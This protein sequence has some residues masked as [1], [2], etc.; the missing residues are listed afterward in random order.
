ML[1]MSLTLKAGL[2]APLL[3]AV[4]MS[5]HATAGKHAIAMHGEPKY[6]ADFK[7]FDY[8]NANA[9]K[10]GTLRRHVIGTFDSFNPFIPQ[11]STATATTTTTT[12]CCR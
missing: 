11:G 12:T 6:S 5:A 8:V 4:A 7:H 10:G 3:F 2:L 1:K 9:P